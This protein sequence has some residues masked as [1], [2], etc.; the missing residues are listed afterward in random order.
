MD[1]RNS[2][3]SKR[4]VEEPLGGRFTEL[5]GIAP[6][7]YITEWR[8]QKAL[9]RLGSSKASVKE[10]A[11]QA[12]YNRRPPLRGHFPNA[13][14]FL[15]PILVILNRHRFAHRPT[16]LQTVRTLFA[17]LAPASCTILGE[18]CCE[19]SPLSNQKESIVQITQQTAHPCSSTSIPGSSPR[20]CTLTWTILL[21]RA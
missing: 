20:R 6:M 2:R 16:V 11:A 14:E 8:L 19:Q 10:V 21:L 13:L 1:G 17:C 3:K 12:G 4:H 18:W 15:R 9:A 5:V 7:A